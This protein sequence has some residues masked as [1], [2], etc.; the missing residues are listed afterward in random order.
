MK[1]IIILSALLAICVTSSS[2]T[3]AGGSSIPS[4]SR[5]QEAISRVQPKIEK[6]FTSKNLEFGASIYIRIFKKEK[7][8]EIW[9]SGNGGFTLFREYPICTYG[10]GSLGPKTKQGDGQAPEGFYYVRPNQLNP[11]SNF[12]LSFNLGYPNQYDRI[13][14]RTGSALMVH[15]SCVSI[16]CY[17]MTDEKI[18]EIYAI[19]DAAFRNDQRFISVHIFPFRM[20]DENMQRHGKSKWYLFWQ[21]LKEGYDFFEKHGNIPPKSLS[22]NNISSSSSCRVSRQ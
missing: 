10:S 19:A 15:G 13:H 7:E 22:D 11:V 18:E 20:T 5:S 4:S 9:V 12:H 17:A 14:K 16:G 8:L 3:I 2:T 21:N 6:D 1:K